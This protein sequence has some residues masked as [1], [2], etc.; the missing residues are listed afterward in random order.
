MWETRVGTDR[1]ALALF[2]S[3]SG[4][5][6]PDLAERVWLELAGRQDEPASAVLD[7]ETFARLHESAADY[8][9]RPVD[10]T[11]PLLALR[12]AVRVAP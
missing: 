9:Y 8:G 1:S 2:L 4:A 7:T 12:L 11:V 3:D 6:R 10:G 5:M